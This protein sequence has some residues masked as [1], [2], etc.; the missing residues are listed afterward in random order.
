MLPRERSK[1]KVKKVKDQ[2]E[3]VKKD[4]AAALWKKATLEKEKAKKDM[5][6]VWKK[7]TLEKEKEKRQ[8]ERK[9]QSQNRRRKGICKASLNDYQQKLQE[10]QEMQKKQQDWLKR[11]EET[12]GLRQ[13]QNSSS[14]PAEV[15]GKKAQLKPNPEKLRLEKKPEKPNPEKLR[16]EKKPEQTNK[17]AEEA[18]EEYSYVYEEDPEEESSSSSEE[19]EPCVGK[20][21][22]SELWGLKKS[23]GKKISWKEN[24]RWS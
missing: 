7:A 21:D 13:S 19:V 5:P 15:C 16:L 6:V 24:L 10:V 18:G 20:V 12:E 2:R 3:K 11:M 4:L 14:K 23:L 1:D 8:R 17:K 9:R 22:F